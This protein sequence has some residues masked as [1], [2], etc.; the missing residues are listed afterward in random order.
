VARALRLDYYKLRRRVP[1]AEAPTVV[2]ETHPRFVEVQLAPTVDPQRPRFHVE[3]ASPGGAC[4]R[5]DL[6]H[7]VPAVVTLAQAFWKGVP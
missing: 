6:G 7:D 2:K 3:F 4:M 1:D 5:I